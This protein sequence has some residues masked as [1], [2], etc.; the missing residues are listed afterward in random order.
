MLQAWGGWVLQAYEC[1][2]GWSWVLQAWGGWVLQA[3]EC[4]RWWGWVLQAYE[5]IEG[6]GLGVASS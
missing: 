2:E 1:I 6:V 4:I 5:C 3:H